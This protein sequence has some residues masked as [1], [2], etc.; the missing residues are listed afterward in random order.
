M[1]APEY[2]VHRNRSPHRAHT[3][4]LHAADFLAGGVTFYKGDTVWF[5]SVPDRHTDETG[6][7]GFGI[8][9]GSGARDCLGTHVALASYHS[10]LRTWGAHFQDW[11]STNPRPPLY[12]PTLKPKGMNVIITKRKDTALV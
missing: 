2:D 3:A 10:F 4:I 8:G 1:A 5:L 12:Y 7:N 9:F 11:S 6:K